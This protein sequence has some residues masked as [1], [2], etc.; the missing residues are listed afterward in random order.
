MKHQMALMR[1]S[2][3]SPGAEEKRARTRLLHMHENAAID[4]LRGRL[5]ASSII[6]SDRVLYNNI[7]K[8]GAASEP[9]SPPAKKPRRE[10]T[11]DSRLAALADRLSHRKPTRYNLKEWKL[12]TAKSI[13][14][15]Q[16][17]YPNS[18]C[19]SFRF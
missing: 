17:Y 14:L 8:R 10:V 5:R 2:A 19:F 1:A 18:T 12:Y 6:P 4:A 13:A 3:H 9:E 16:P 15:L 11:F 7:H